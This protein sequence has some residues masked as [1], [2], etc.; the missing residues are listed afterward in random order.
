M[1]WRDPTVAH[2]ARNKAAKIIGTRERIVVLSRVAI[3]TGSA[4]A[5][6]RCAYNQYPLSDL[7]FFQFHVSN[8]AAQQIKLVM[9]R[10]VH[11]V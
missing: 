11:T 4:I 3:A 9:P 1:V 2:H 6:A 7:T 8:V 5:F 10:R